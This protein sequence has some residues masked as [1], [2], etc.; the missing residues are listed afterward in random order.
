MQLGTVEL[1]KIPRVILAINDDNLEEKLFKARELK[2]DLIEARI[3]L[4]KNL[5]KENIKRFLDTIG[6]FGFYTVATVRPM[7]E[8]GKFSKDEEKRLNTIKEVAEHPVVAAIDIE[9][10]AE[11]IIKRVITYTKSLRKKVIVSFHDF[12]KTPSS[13]EILNIASRAKEI[14]GDIVKCA[15]KANSIQDVSNTACTMKSIDMPKI[16]MLMGDKGS[17]SRVDGFFFGSLL[18]Y[19]FFGESVAPGQIEAENLIKLLMKF[20]PDYRKEKLKTEKVI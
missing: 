13:D 20:Y 2:I 16:F 10:R 15:F 12:E 19:T 6:D 5:S 3:D 14:G 8:G 9:L 17:I 1:G 18:T 7:W 11:K 4:L